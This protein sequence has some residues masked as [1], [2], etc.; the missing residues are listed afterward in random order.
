MSVTLSVSSGKARRNLHDSLAALTGKQ[1]LVGVPATTAQ[2]RQA[3][4]T[5]LAVSA[6]GRRRKRLQ[7]MSGNTINNAE[8]LYLHTHGS[9]LKHIPARPV[10]EAAI[11]DRQNSQQIVAEL[12]LAATAAI[13]GKTD[14]VERQLRLAGTV[15]ANLA[16]AWF[17]NPR[18]H[19]A[20]NRP[21]T[22]QR[23]GSSRPL[24]DTGALRK[25]ITYVVVSN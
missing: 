2:D 10:V 15:A 22:V 11:S 20:P 24:I 7:G 8:L 21:R 25:A 12:R 9:P 4:V 16:R 19:W 23:K 1:V 3:Q 6:R 17:T 14:L 18:N 13:E 5:K